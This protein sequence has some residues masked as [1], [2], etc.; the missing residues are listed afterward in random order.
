[1]SLLDEI[2]EERELIKN[3]AL[4][5]ADHLVDQGKEQIRLGES[6]RPIIAAIHGDQTELFYP[7]WRN[8]WERDKKFK[9]ID[10]TLSTMDIDATVCRYGG[11]YL[12]EA[13]QSIEDVRRNP[14]SV[15]AIIVELK[16]ANWKETIIHP[17]VEVDEVIAWLEPRSLPDYLNQTEAISQPFVN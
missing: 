6:V 10:T 17:Y 15:K 11:K 8:D 12:D 14:K 3:D 5:L 16:T 7:Q 9:E 4:T 13:G 1:M 2:N